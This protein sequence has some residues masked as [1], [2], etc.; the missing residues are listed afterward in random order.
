MKK[1]AKS[2]TAR[3]H[4]PLS[5]I[6]DIRKIEV[7][8]AAL[9]THYLT[10]FKICIKIDF[11]KISYSNQAHLTATTSNRVPVLSEIRC[12]MS[13]S[14]HNRASASVLNTCA[15]R[16]EGERKEESTSP[17]AN[18]LLSIFFQLEK[19]VSTAQSN[20]L[21]R[22]RDSFNRPISTSSLSWALSQM[23]WRPWEFLSWPQWGLDQTHSASNLIWYG[24]VNWL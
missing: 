21:K 8:I 4:P 20:L 2:T 1:L 3:S 17:Y 9:L 10:G 13:V 6:L 16:E 15:R 18:M 23:C 7:L 14:W 24:C 12:F 22:A 19:T 11:K 5:L